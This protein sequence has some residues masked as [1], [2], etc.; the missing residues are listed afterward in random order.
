MMTPEKI[1]D[2]FGM[3]PMPDEGGYYVETYRAAEK[4]SASVLPQRYT[5]TRNI[6]TAI[7]YLLTPET[8]S[9]MHR[10]KSDEVFHFYLGDPVTMLMLGP[11]GKSQIVTL[12]QDILNGQELQQMIPAG[13]WQGCC[14][15]DGGKFALMGTTVAPGFEFDDYEHAEKNELL[16]KYPQQ[17]ELILRLVR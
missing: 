10:V 7:L 4:L 3:K 13:I 2:F 5:G 17:K 8:F 12:G 1:I 11:K 15:K 6:S 9:A 16:E 14:L